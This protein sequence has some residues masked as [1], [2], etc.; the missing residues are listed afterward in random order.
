MIDKLTF[1]PQPMPI[2]YKYVSQDAARKIIGNGSLRFGRPSGMNDP[3]DVYIDD[4]FNLTIEQLQTR[5]VPELLDLVHT[6]PSRFQEFVGADPTEVNRVAGIINSIPPHERQAHYAAIT[7]ALFEVGDETFAEMSRSLEIERQQIVAQFEN[8]AL[9]CITR[10]RD[11][12]LMWAHYADQHRGVVFGFRPDI[13][14]DSF[15]AVAK[16]VQYSDKRPA[17]Y[18]RL[19]EKIAMNRP[20]TE[21]ELAELRNALIYSK[22][23][24][25]SYEEKPG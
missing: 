18:Q 4:L 1:M 19:D 24:H 2:V 13:E 7:A 6:N 15:L 10:S 9:L 12:L 3:F 21:G 16:P 8:T 20:W 14:R 17:F 11:N 22:S 23:T 5:A 25:W